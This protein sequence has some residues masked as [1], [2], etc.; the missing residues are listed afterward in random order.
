ME[1]GCDYNRP[2]VIYENIHDPWLNSIFFF[3]LEKT[4][5]YNFL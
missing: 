3:F 1:G 2:K 4:L 5:F